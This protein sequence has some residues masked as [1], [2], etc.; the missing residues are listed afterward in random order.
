MQQKPEDIT[1][2]P[3]E[4][5][6][7][8]QWLMKRGGHD[9]TIRS[10]GEY[11]LPF[12]LAAMEA[13]WFNG[14]LIGLAG[15]DFLHSGSA[16]LPFWG[17]PLLLFVTVGLFRR[18]LQQEAS[19]ENGQVGDEDE[20]KAR[21]LPG[22]GLLFGVLALLDIGLIWLHVYAPTNFLLDPTW[23]LTFASDLFSL[24]SRFYQALA[25]VL[26][27]LY[28]CWRGLKL[29]Q[30]NIEP[31]HVLRQMWIGL[32]IL[33]VA[34][35]LRA[36]QFS[37]SG[38]ADDAVLVLLIPVFLYLSLST[39]ALARITFIRR[40]HPFGLEGSVTAQERS[41]LS[42]ITGVGLVLLILTLFGGSFFSAAFFNSLQPIGQVLSI[43]YNWLV[44]AFS[45]IAVWIVTPFLWLLTWWFSHFSFQA[46]RPNQPQSNVKPPSR[47]PP[48][49]STSPVIVHVVQ[50]VLP[51]LILLVLILLL[52]L[53]LRRRKRLRIALNRKGGD[54]HE[55]IWSWSLFWNQLKAF[56]HSFFQRFF[57]KRAEEKQKQV[58]EEMPAEPAARTIREIYRALLKKAA[59]HGHIRKRDETPHEFQQRLDLHNS[60]NEPQLGQLTEAY[61]LTRYGGAIP[62]DF[63]V[64][65]LQRSW[66]ELEQKWEM[67]S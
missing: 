47:V 41:M 17:P 30:V 11:F 38:S 21:N 10:L 53:A 45:L 39:H 58:A 22:L 49:S 62:N 40:E 26:I 56:W 2:Q 37:T 6:T 42:V 57:P 33:L 3:G 7:P 55:N 12:F 65:V 27:T 48:L 13:C 14:I 4:R 20:Q 24:S 52:R 28:F 35:L 36:R 51:L 18:S 59:I 23:L 29:A 60:Q 8:L 44:M 34:I 64:A 25:I 19:A 67:S 61:T 46:I 66:S 9:I 43:A 63:E 5:I 54:I 32:L 31:G 50:I 16:L 15:V 1:A